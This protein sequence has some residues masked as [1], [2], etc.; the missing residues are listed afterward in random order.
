MNYP[1][2]KAYPGDFFR[3]TVGMAPEL[4]GYYRMLID[5]IYMHD[6]RL[7]DSNRYISGMFGC[8]PNKVAYI[9]R[10]LLKAGKITIQDGAILNERATEEVEKRENLSKSSAKA[11]Q[12]LAK[13]G[14]SFSE[15]TQ[16]KQWAKIAYKK[17]KQNSARGAREGGV[18][19]GED[20]EGVALPAEGCPTRPVAEALRDVSVRLHA[21]ACPDGEVALVG[22]VFYP[23]LAAFD[24]VART[25][26]A[27]PDGV[28][29]CERND[30][31]NPPA[32]LEA[33]A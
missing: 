6:G 27:W 25:P 20:L 1:F 16:Q 5:L 11:G 9:K 7:S 2:Y 15:K 21:M 18:F 17:Q 33:V 10:E 24:A 8:T 13:S 23:P 26:I 3:A 28:R 12:K 31:G 29:L 32:G 4:K 14:G 22:G 19:G 30:A